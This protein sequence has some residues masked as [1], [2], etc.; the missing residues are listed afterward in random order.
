MATERTIKVEVIWKCGA[1]CVRVGGEFRHSE[2]STVGSDGKPI[3]CGTCHARLMESMPVQP[4]V[5]EESSMN[6]RLK[7][8]RKDGKLTDVTLVQSMPDV[9]KIKIGGIVFDAKD[10]ELSVPIMEDGEIVDDGFRFGEGNEYDR[11]I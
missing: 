5:V 2:S 6:R 7:V 9:K 8:T 3:C 4:I 10:V 1:A 11:R